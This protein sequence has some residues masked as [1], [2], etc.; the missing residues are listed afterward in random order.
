[1]K[2][3]LTEIAS[4][5]G[6]QFHYEINEPGVESEDVRCVEPITGS[7]DFT[8]AGRHIIARGSFKT[9]IMLQCSRCLEDFAFPIDIKIEEELPITS[10]Q[11]LLAGHEEEIEEE[12]KEPLFQDNVFDLSEYL[13]QMILVET[14]IQPI[15]DDACKGL[16]P[17]CGVNRNREECECSVDLSG[18]PFASLSDMLKDSE[19]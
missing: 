11:A 10:L 18:S 12:E 4:E 2:L 5:V 17:T 1:M 13:R 16:C 8:N 19:E 3:D 14:P 7:I 9:R 15:C 6:K